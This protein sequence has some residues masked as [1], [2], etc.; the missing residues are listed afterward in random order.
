L[1]YAELIK[2]TNPRDAA[3]IFAKYFER[4][5]NISIKRMDNAEN[6]YNEY[7]KNAADK[8]A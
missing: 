8:I 7:T 4:P 3:E 2:Q 1:G 5:A 6:Y